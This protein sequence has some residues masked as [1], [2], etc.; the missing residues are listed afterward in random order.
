M[1]DVNPGAIVNR[2]LTSRIRPVPSLVTHH[3]GVVRNDIRIAMKIVQ[4]LDRRWNLWQ[5][6][7]LE[8][9]VEPEVPEVT[10]EAA[11][12]LSAE[13][14]SKQE[15]ENNEIANLEKAAFS[16]VAPTGPKYLPH[17]VSYKNYEI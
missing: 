14:L 3:K 7:S 17:K 9:P 8:E 13:P 11:A 6:T 12:A 16:K 1:K 15:A 5:E 10:P 4:N 2:D